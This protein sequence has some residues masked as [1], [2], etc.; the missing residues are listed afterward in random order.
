ML[1][2]QL[3]A[4][5]QELEQLPRFTLPEELQW[6]RKTNQRFDVYNEE[7][8]KWRI[9]HPGV[10]EK[11]Q[12]L[13]EEI[14]RIEYEILR[15]AQLA[16]ERKQALL[17]AGCGVRAVEAVYAPKE[18]QAIE[19]ARSWYKGKTTFLLMCGSLASGKSVAAVETLRLRLEEHTSIYSS[20]VKFICATE[21]S[22]LT[23]HNYKT[24]EQI[25]LLKKVP[26]LVVDDAG[27]ETTNDVIRQ[28]MFEILNARYANMLRTVLT[29]NLPP[30]SKDNSDSFLKSYGDRVARR[31]REDGEVVV[32]K[33]ALKF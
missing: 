17:K 3:E 31:I 18:T 6:T 21:M 15:Q 13:W 22:R 5:K 11:A 10:H 26:M 12:A 4:L 32:L 28:N 16:V 19:A 1:S 24:A 9:T 33:E 29:T 14:R 23:A 25:E 30:S 20:L 2:A 8:E 7:Y 27:A